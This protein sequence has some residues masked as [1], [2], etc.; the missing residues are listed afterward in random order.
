MGCLCFPCIVTQSTTLVLEEDE[1]VLVNSGSP[2]SVPRPP[3]ASLVEALGGGPR[4]VTAG[5]EERDS[6]ASCSRRAA[7]R[8]RTR[9]YNMC[10]FEKL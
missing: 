4:T 8:H 2:S 3:L 9:K 10:I 1:A 5:A 7:P 6:Q